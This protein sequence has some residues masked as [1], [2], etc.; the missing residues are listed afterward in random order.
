MVKEIIKENYTIPT[1]LSKFNEYIDVILNRLDS[2]TDSSTNKLL[3]LQCIVAQYLFNH[4]I[5][6]VLDMS[7]EQKEKLLMHMCLKCRKNNNAYHQIFE[8]MKK[9]DGIL[10]IIDKNF[11]HEEIDF[12]GI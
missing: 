7:I 6:N 11:T 3:K 12:Y 1:N 8:S 5:Y 4:G 10:S 2:N 9:N